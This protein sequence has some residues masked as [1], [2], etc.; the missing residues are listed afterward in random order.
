MV[1]ARPGDG[2]GGSL[3]LW[4][5]GSALPREGEAQLPENTEN[6]HLI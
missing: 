2:G 3:V 1:M 6:D 5:G 4:A